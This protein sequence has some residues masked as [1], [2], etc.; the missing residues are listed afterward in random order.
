[1]ASAVFELSGITPAQSR[2]AS[3]WIGANAPNALLWMAEYTPVAGTTDLDQNQLRVSLSSEN[4]SLVDT[5]RTVIRD[6][7]NVLGWTITKDALVP[8][9]RAELASCLQ[10]SG[11][12]LANRPALNTCVRAAWRNAGRIMTREERARI[13]NALRNQ[14]LTFINGDPVN[15]LKQLREWL[16]ETE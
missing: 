7:L 12:S 2:A 11:T 3:N 6:R 16:L 4:D 1:M 5:A 10:T 15:N 14:Q 9:L 13:L 8:T